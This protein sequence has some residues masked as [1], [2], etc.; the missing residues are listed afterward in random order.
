MAKNT[1]E[2]I[3]ALKFTVIS[4]SA[5]IIQ[6]GSFT[7]LNEVFKLQ[8]PEISHLIALIL[9][10]VWNF[11]INRK[12]TF[13]SSNNVVKSMI[14]VALFYVVFTPASTF[15]MKDRCYC[16]CSEGNTGRIIEDK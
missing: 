13:K 11:T 12:V 10:V 4:L 2:I 3:R 8:N 9:S 1:K 15:F 16:W 7:L 14:L 5:G 6:I